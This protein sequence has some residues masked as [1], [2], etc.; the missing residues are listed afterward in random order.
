MLIYC[1]SVGQQIEHCMGGSDI[2]RVRPA[3][4]YKGEFSY[5]PSRRGVVL[6]LVIT[7]DQS[8]NKHPL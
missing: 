1:W 8:G 7:S 5:N 4:C 2:K 6:S 3:S